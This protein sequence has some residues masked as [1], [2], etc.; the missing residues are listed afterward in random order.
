MSDYAEGYVPRRHSSKYPLLL[1]E[2]RDEHAFH[3]SKDELFHKCEQVFESICVTN[4]QVQLVEEKTRQQADCKEWHR[5][6]TGRTTASRMKAVCRTSVEKPARSLIKAICYPDT[7]RFRT[8]ATQWGYQHEEDGLAAY[9]SMIDQSQDSFKVEKSGFVISSDYPYIRESPDSMVECSC[10]GKGTVE[11]KCP[12]CVR[13]KET[14]E[15]PEKVSCMENVAGKVQLR[16]SHQYYYQIQT[17]VFVCN[18]DYCDFVIL[19]E[20]GLHHA[21]SD[22]I[23]ERATGFFKRAVL[24]ELIRKHFSKIQPATSTAAQGPPTP[25]NE[26]HRESVESCP[27]SAQ[28]KKDCFTCTMNFGECQ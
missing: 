17:Q 14:P 26:H 11:V 10:C 1:S 6:R 22:E 23:C 16:K 7:V 20:E 13:D 3:L 21:L 19:T 12:H 27:S 24:P 2:L 9:R 18:V 25:A 5:F 15:C 4:D 28:K 8:K